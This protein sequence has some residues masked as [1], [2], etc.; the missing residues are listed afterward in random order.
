M[1]LTARAVLVPADASPG[2][3]AAVVVSVLRNPGQ[4][5]RAERR[6]DSAAA[7]TGPRGPRLGGTLDDFYGSLKKLRAGIR[8]DR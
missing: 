6:R 3:F 2:E 7:R 5:P 4:Q 8:A 1:G